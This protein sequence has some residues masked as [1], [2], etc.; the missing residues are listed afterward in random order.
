MSMLDERYNAS[1]DTNT[2]GIQDQGALF[3]TLFIDYV[4]H[5]SDDER[6]EFLESA[7][8][9]A[10]CEANGG[11]KRRTIVRLSKQDD[12]NR[13]ITLAAMEKAKQQNS[14]DWKRLKKAQ[15]ARK[16]AIAAIVKKYGMS[17]K[18]DVLKAQ[19]ALIKADSRYYTKT[20]FGNN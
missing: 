14:S 6:K 11:I 1:E 20:N 2:D 10:L 17:V 12:Y 5:M 19:K 16:A 18:R 15:R 7:E 8:V 4:N 9:K 13:R 3:E